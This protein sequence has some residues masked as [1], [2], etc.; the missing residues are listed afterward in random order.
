MEFKTFFSGI[1]FPSVGIFPAGK[2]IVMVSFLFHIARWVHRPGLL[3]AL[4][5]IHFEVKTEMFNSKLLD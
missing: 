3:Q 5:P 2:A 4:S 1:I